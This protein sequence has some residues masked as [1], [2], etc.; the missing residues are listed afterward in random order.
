MVYPNEYNGVAISIVSFFLVFLV[1]FGYIQTE[2][3]TATY[4][5][6]FNIQVI[7]KKDQN[8][9][10]KTFKIINFE[11]YRRTAKTYCIYQD[12]TK[13]SSVNLYYN[14]NDNESG[15]YEIQNKWQVEYVRNLRDTNS[16]QWPV[17]Y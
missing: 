11:K 1:F 17:Y 14:D 7:C 13:N 4:K 16:L 12:S 9:D 2:F 8:P 6:E 15:N 3:L 10:W 5:S